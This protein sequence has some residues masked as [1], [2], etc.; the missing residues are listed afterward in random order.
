[1]YSVSFLYFAYFLTFYYMYLLISFIFRLRSYLTNIQLFVSLGK[2]KS[3]TALLSSGVPQRTVLS[4]LV[5]S[6]V[7]MAF[8]FSATQIIFSLCVCKYPIESPLKTPMAVLVVGHIFI[9]QNIWFLCVYWGCVCQT[10]P[11]NL[12]VLLDP[13]MNFNQH[14]KSLTKMTFYHLHTNAHLWPLLT[15]NDAQTLAN[16]LIMSHIDYCNS[17]LTGLSALLT[18]ILSQLHWWPVLSVSNSKCCYSPSKH[19]MASWPLTVSLVLSGYLAVI[20]LL[21]LPCTI[22]GRSFSA[23]VPNTLE[24]S[25]SVSLWLFFMFYF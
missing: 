25:S 7:V 20:C 15:S 22:G 4:S 24:I 9:I 6:F 10:Y 1:M 8:T 12:G 14:F 3:S 23:I 2:C 11:F 19:C 21:L 13:S 17:L 18:P 16:A 5:R